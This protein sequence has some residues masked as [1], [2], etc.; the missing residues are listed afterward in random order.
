M[1]RKIQFQNRFTDLF[2]EINHIDFHIS[3]DQ[4]WF[5]RLKQRSLLSEFKP[6][7]PTESSAQKKHGTNITKYAIKKTKIHHLMHKYRTYNRFIFL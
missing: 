2:L 1:R 3:F 5:L 7:C 6:S 4:K